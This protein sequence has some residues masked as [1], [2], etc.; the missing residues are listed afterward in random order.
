M[1]TNLFIPKKLKVGFKLQSDTYA[2]KLAYVIYYDEK[3]KLRKE[4][5][6]ESWRHKEIDTFELDN[7]PFDGFVLNKSITRYGWDHFSQNV[8]KIRIYDN[9]GIEFEIT[10][11]N[12]LGILT[13]VNCVKR[14]LQG[15]FVY[16]WA[17]QELV[18]LPCSSVEYTEAVQFT[19]IRQQRLTGKQ[20]VPGHV[21][22][23]KYNDSLLYLGR[24][25]EGVIAK[26]AENFGIDI[27]KKFVF[28]K[29]ITTQLDQ[30]LN[31]ANS[32]SFYANCFLTKDSCS[33]FIACE[34][35]KDGGIHP[36]FATIYSK[37]MEDRTNFEKIKRVILEPTDP[38]E[39]K[40]L[41]S[42]QVNVFVVMKD[43]P[44]YAYQLYT[45][46]NMT[47]GGNVDKTNLFAFSEPW[48]LDTELKALARVKPTYNSSS[49]GYYNPVAQP[50]IDTLHDA[51]AKA[52]RYLNANLPD[53]A[54]TIN[55][56]RVVQAYNST[57]VPTSLDTIRELI[58]EAKKA[59]CA[60]ALAWYNNI[61][62][63]FSDLA[64]RCLTVKVEFESGTISPLTKVLRYANS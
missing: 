55:F 41:V 24:L 27:K 25:S 13:C 26:S 30:N 59:E 49:F 15:K 54:E 4:T 29:A 36:D 9:R 37:Y 52:V 38:E 14:D 62:G 23:T 3:G 5:S 19:G 2:G 21:Y 61:Y 17:G 39:I 11:E 60:G 46:Q 20:L 50:S 63:K 44:S 7:E 42:R 40:D 6:L 10:V 8:T 34:K 31:T 47:F 45:S 64:D 18:L 58:D 22:L 56:Q 53:S 48:K 43:K 16:A 28:S 51:I 35:D 32:L 33:D 57:C 12:L 1:A